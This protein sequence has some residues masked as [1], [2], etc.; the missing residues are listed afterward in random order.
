MPAGFCWLGSAS[1]PYSVT[2]IG[3]SPA[4]CVICRML[5]SAVPISPF[6]SGGSGSTYGWM[7]MISNA[8]HAPTSA[9]VRRKVVSH[10]FS[11][12]IKIWSSGAATRMAGATALSRRA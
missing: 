11:P 1:Q 10:G 4:H 8:H 7:A 12:P 9:I 2:Q 3:F 5:L 6:A